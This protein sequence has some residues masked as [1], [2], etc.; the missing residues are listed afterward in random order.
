MNHLSI[1]L[2]KVILLIMPKSI[3]QPIYHVQPSY[4][5][6]RGKNFYHLSFAVIFF[7]VK[8]QAQKYVI[9]ANQITLRLIIQ[10]ILDS[11]LF[12]CLTQIP[13]KVRI[14]QNYVYVIYLIQ[15]II[16]KETGSQS[17]SYEISLKGKKKALLSHSINI[18]QNLIVLIL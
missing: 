16:I 18:T 7:S 4:A 2:G 13:R 14:F 11:K 1:P 10:E 9:I 6:V 8:H 17:K 5:D 3:S 15:I 12:S